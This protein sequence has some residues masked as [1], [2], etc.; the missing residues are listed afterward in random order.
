MFPAMPFHGVLS[1]PLGLAR[2]TEQPKPRGGSHAP[3][4]EFPDAT[5]HVTH[6][7]GPSTPL[8]RIRSFGVAQDDTE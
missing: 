7:R 1:M 3:S 4:R 6:S 5:C 2:T 8:G